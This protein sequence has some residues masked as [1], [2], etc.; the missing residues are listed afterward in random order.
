MPDFIRR[1]ISLKP[2]T[3]FKI[4]GDAEYFAI[5]TT[6]E[7]LKAATSWATA[8]QIP[9]TVIGGGSNI[10]VNDIKVPGLVICMQALGIVCSE[11]TTKVTLTAQA[12][13]SWDMFVA[14]CVDRNYWGVENLSGIP[15]SV[16]ATPVQNVGAYGVE[17]SERISHVEVFD[18]VEQKVKIYSAE[19]CKFTYRDSIFKRSD[20]KHIIILSVTY[21]LSRLPKPNLEYK[22]LRHHIGIS[23]HS[24]IH[25]IRDAVLNIRAQKFPDL[26]QYGTGGSFFKNPIISTEQFRTLQQK[27]PA[28]VGNIHGHHIKV[29]AGWLIDKVANYKGVRKKNVGSYATQ[30]LVIVNYGN[31]SAREVKKFI[32]EIQDI[33]F[34]KTAI[35]LE[36]EI[37]FL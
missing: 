4:G 16:G 1:S 31:A 32:T 20:H 9:V 37:N 35:M 27:Y 23:S 28:I 5:V 13:V 18:A 15:G 8:Q 22:D 33:I 14:Y 24:S 19:E 17:V 7:E 21:K 29:S 25:T 10:L 6:L 3:T 12:G 26:T 2:Y 30:A 34:T 36:P 11:K